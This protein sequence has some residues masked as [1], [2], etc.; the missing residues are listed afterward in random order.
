MNRQLDRLIAFRV[1]TR[2]TGNEDEKPVKHV[3]EGEIL[4]SNNR[5]HGKNNDKDIIK[6]VTD[7]H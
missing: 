7:S 4:K 5:K 1:V 2:N 6:T 3:R